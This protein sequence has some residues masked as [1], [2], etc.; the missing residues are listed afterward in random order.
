MRISYKADRRRFVYIGPEGTT[1]KAGGVELEARF[2][3]SVTDELA[4][5]LENR[6]GV[7]EILHVHQPS[8]PLGL[9]DGDDDD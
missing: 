5:L 7:E 9:K 6:R 4:K 1:L 2:V 3:Y 8:K